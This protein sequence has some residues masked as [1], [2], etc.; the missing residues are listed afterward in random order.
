MIG[1]RCSS[2]SQR[3]AVVDATVRSPS[4]SASLRLL[5][6]ALTTSTLKA[7]PSGVLS[8]GSSVVTS[9]PGAG[10][11]RQLRISGMS[12]PWDWM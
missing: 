5:E 4:T 12:S 10:A 11:H 3:S 9:G 6:P 2:P 7:Q 8:V 1:S